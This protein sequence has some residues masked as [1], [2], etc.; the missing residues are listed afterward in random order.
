MRATPALERFVRDT[1]GC[2]C[3]DAVFEHVERSRGPLQAGGAEAAEWIGIGGRLLIAVVDRDAVPGLDTGL[4]AA[5]AEGLQRRDAGGFNRFRLVVP[6]VAGL[7]RAA[8]E[9]AFDPLGAA[10]ERLH[11]HL[12]APEELPP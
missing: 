4:A 7:D 8:L 6:V 2:G 9:Q 5:C 12:V 3:P 11:L 10:D 1:L